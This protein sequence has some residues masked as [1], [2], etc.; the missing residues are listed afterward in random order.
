MKI[1]INQLYIVIGGMVPTSRD[2]SSSLARRYSLHFLGGRW[3]Y[4]E[5]MM[6]VYGSQL[7]LFLFQPWLLNSSLIVNIE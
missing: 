1:I 6:G 4:L 7:C 3:S 2:A 5:E